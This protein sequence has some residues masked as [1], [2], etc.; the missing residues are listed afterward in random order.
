[1]H[2]CFHCKP[3]DARN[4][5]FEKISKQNGLFLNRKVFSVML[6]ILKLTA[7]F[8][9]FFAMENRERSQMY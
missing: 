8:G 3:F 2:F 7:Y 1:M 5:L 6:I 4:S 9:F